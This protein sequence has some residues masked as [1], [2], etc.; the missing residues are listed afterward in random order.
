MLAMNLGM[1]LWLSHDIV[2][3]LIQT[4]NPGAGDLR[5]KQETHGVTKHK[6]GTYLAQSAGLFLADKYTPLS[7]SV[8]QQYA[9]E[10]TCNP[11]E[12]IDQLSLV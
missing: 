6:R 3:S 11:G 9:M 7:G 1:T 5:G 2:T 4:D 8:K 12:T 10:G